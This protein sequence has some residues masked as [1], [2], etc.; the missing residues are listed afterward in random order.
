MQVQDSTPWGKEVRYVDSGCNGC[1]MTLTRPVVD[2]G[3]KAGMVWVTRNHFGV[4][5]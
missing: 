2:C 5:G 1:R 4:Y 3:V